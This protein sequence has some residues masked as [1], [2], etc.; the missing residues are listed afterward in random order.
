[1]GVCKIVRDIC[2]I[3]LVSIGGKRYRI[4]GAERKFR[5]R[6]E[7]PKCGRRSD[8]D[9]LN[10]LYIEENMF[11][12]HRLETMEAWIVRCKCG[13]TFLVKE[14]DDYKYYSYYPVEKIV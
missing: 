4:T 1:M 7:C 8:I 6:F 12:L 2:V 9:G 11:E 14:R 3:D 5:S 10:F 13:T